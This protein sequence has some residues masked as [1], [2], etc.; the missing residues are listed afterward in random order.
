MKKIICITLLF[1]SSYCFG[2]DIFV[3]T[4]DGGTGDNLWTTVANWEMNGS[5]ATY[6]PGSTAGANSATGDDVVIF[7]TDATD[8]DCEIN[9]NFA[10]LSSGL[11][12]GGMIA[13][14]YV[15]TITQ[16]D[17]NR[18]IISD[19]VSASGVGNPDLSTLI[20]IDLASILDGTTT[21]NALNGTGAY[22]ATFNFGTGGNFQGGN[23][24]VGG[25]N[26]SLFVTVPLDINSGSFVAPRDNMIIRYHTTIDNTVFDGLTQEGT[27]ILSS[28]T[29]LSPTTTPINYDFSNVSFNNLSISSIG[30]EYVFSGGASGSF[31]VTND[32]TTAGNDGLATDGG[33]GKIKMSGAGTVI[34]IQGDMILANVFVNPNTGVTYYGDIML[35]LNNAVADQ[36][37][38]HSS[39]ANFAGVLPNLTIN[40]AAGDVIL[41]GPVSIQDELVFIEGIVRP[42]P[43]S[44]NPSTQSDLNSANDMFVLNANA[45][46][47]GASNQ[48]FC[49]GPI[50]KR[51]GTSIELPIGKDGKY[52][53][54]TLGLTG[55]VDNNTNMYTAEYF[56][57]TASVGTGTYQ[58]PITLV[59]ICEVWGI[60]K[61]QHDDYSFKLGLNYDAVD[62]TFLS[63]TCALVVSRWDGATNGWVTHGNGGSASL[64]SLEDI[65][66][67]SVDVVDDPLASLSDF[68]RSTTAPDLFTFSKINTNTCD[69]CE[70]DLIVNYCAAGCEFI[71][72]ALPIMGSGTHKISIQW[73]FDGLGSDTGIA[74]TFTFT[75]SGIHTIT[76]TIMGYSLT[77]GD[78]C[79][80][81]YEFDIITNCDS[82][83]SL[84]SLFYPEIL[85]QNL[86]LYDHSYGLRGT[87]VN[88]WNW[89]VATE[90]NV[91]YSTEKNPEFH[92]LEVGKA[93]ICL[94]VYGGENGNV[95]SDKSCRTIFI[96]EEEEGSALNISPNPVT[97]GIVI[98]DFEST[99]I[100]K[101][102]YSIFDNRG[103]LVL[104]GTVSTAEGVSIDVSKLLTGTYHVMVYMSNE[105]MSKKIIIIN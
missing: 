102:T 73:D 48:S 45:T 90:S 7:S 18:L 14:D 76:A 32:F 68:V 62:C 29:S 103:V 19:G 10:G 40:K 53:P 58:S 3:W 60:Q 64:A 39:A 71:F 31:D 41:S 1:V 75:T 4:N 104:E 25:L 5:A 20:V 54:A 89:T 30:Y 59:S 17:D 37:I 38:I 84:N 21:G 6:F 33:A 47:S 44:L 101:H 36:T 70:I 24:I 2:Q 50:R 69:S 23:T 82:S 15:G 97:N 66:Y 92:D 88:S 35:E 57:G 46:V 95:I 83:G 74:P 11:R 72:D 52:K 98:L 100:D 105:V 93:E 81:E 86:S 61:S 13:E 78:S 28:R 42:D 34:R 26:Y 94:T 77:T 49:E 9:P 80:G 51:R 63:D 8:D 79:M 96:S 99:S 55:G 27:V 56:D 65:Q 87:K 91:Y 85:T 22:R 67:A 12:I 43:T 16:V